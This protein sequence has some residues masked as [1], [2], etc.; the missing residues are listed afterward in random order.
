MH[1]TIMTRGNRWGAILGSLVLVLCAAEWS[2]AEPE[3]GRTDGPESSEYGQGGYSRFRAGGQVYVEGFFGA[4]AVDIEREDG[5][6]DFS[7][8]DLIS[9]FNVGYMTQDWLAI[10]VGFGHISGDQSTD[11]FT[12]GMRNTVIRE[13]FNYFFSLD[14]E[15]YSPDKGGGKFGIVPG[16]GGEIVAVEWVQLGLRFQRDFV[17]A[18]DTIRL[19]RFSA[20]LQFKF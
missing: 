8:T 11:L 14:A 15:L 18:D 1:R 10:Q 12:L 9:G 13:P 4:A 16:I 17:F 5:S 20:R 6:G 19:N 3:P 7:S 2:A